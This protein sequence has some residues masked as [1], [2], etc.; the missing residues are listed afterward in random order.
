M[1]PDMPSFEDYSRR[2]YG[3]LHNLAVNQL[4][5]HVTGEPSAMVST[6]TA[7]VPGSI[8]VDDSFEQPL[9]ILLPFFILIG[10]V[11]PVYNMVFSLVKE[12]ESG[13]KESM[14][15]MGM[16]DAPYWLSWWFHFTG[17]NAILTCISAGILCINIVN[18][19]EPI[20]L[21]LFIFLYGEAVFAQIVFLQAFFSASKYAGI[22]ATIVY[23]SSALLNFFLGLDDVS[24]IAKILASLIP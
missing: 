17:V 12:K 3:Y 16:T 1:E 23:F 4:L 21:F 10:F 7:P 11:P 24:Q 20:Y 14:R 6:L 19:S 22:V 2:G 5:K 15:M 18:Y 13:A 9:S 8:S